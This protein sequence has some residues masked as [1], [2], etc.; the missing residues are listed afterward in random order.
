MRPGSSRTR[1]VIAADTCS[2]S[3]SARTRYKENVRKMVIV[4]IAIRFWW[5]NGEG[6]ILNALKTDIRVTWGS[7]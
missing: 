1:A 2:V 4:L 7:T 5:H 3:F 6:K